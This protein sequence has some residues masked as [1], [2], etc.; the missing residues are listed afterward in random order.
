MPEQ[1]T[2]LP[3]TSAAIKELATELARYLKC[4]IKNTLPPAT[5]WTCQ[6]IS[7]LDRFFRD[8]GC[9]C[10]FT[11]TTCAEFLWDFTAYIPFK[12]ML[13]V[14]ESEHDTDHNK[15]TED[16][17]KLLYSNAPLKLMMCRIEKKYDTRKAAETEAR[18]IQAELLEHVQQNC[19]NYSG[20]DVVVV[21]CV[22]W[23]LKDGKNRDFAYMLQV[24]GEPNRRDAK[25]KSFEPTTFG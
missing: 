12:G 18:R 20:G 10:N 19:M 23:A 14:A 6:N 2:D 15:I 13:L 4:K 22:W 17:D 7:L 1:I 8:R 11:S 3:R 25:G 24:E 16:F 5:N 21:Y 9:D